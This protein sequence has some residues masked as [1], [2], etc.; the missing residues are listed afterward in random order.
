MMNWKTYE[1]EIL[2]IFKGEYPRAQITANVK[3]QGRYSKVSRQC[4]V[5]IEDYVAGNRMRILIDGKY[6]NKKVNVKHVEAFLGML[7]DINAQKGLLITNKGYSKAA[8]NRAFYG[9]AEFELDILSF[10]E[11]QQFQAFGA[12]PYAG[13]DGVLLPAPFGWIIDGSRA[14]GWTAILYQRGLSLDQALNGLEFIY[15]GFW[16]RNKNNESMD[17]LITLQEKN[18]R[19]VDPK[20]KIEYHPTILRDEAR[21]TLRSAQSPEFPVPEY[22]GFIEF[23]DFILFCVL[24]SPIEL[25]KKNLRKLEYIMAKVLPIKVKQ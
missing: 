16:D 9:P 2:E 11:L 17:D 24:R 21:T 1:A 25:H 13:N 18:L 15:I 6:Y 19:G 8:I 3:I 5:L 20:A 22:T 14:P 4:D 10:A 12:I 7:E 23:E